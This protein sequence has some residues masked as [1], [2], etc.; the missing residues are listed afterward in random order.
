MPDH[1]SRI[2]RKP[3]PVGAELKF[4]RDPGDDAEAKIEGKDPRPEVCDFLIMDIARQQ[5]SAAQVEEQ[6]GQSH[7]QL[8]EEIVEGS[9]KGELKP[10]V[11]ERTGHE[12]K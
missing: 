12:V 9:G 3:G 11:E 5:H 10:I 8:W 2:G 1:A 4:K 6:K 7:R